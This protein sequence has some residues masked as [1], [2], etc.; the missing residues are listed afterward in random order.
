MKTNASVSLLLGL[1]LLLVACAGQV[2]GDGSG[3][4]A[5]DDASSLLGPSGDDASNDG[6][7]GAGGPGW[8]ASLPPSNL[9]GSADGAQGT[10]ARDG[11]PAGARPDAS[12]TAPLG[13]GTLVID[14]LMVESVAGTG[15]YGEWL[16]VRSTTPCAVSLRGLHG[17]CPVGMKVHTFDVTDDLWVGPLG[18]FVVADSTDP[19][20]NHDVPGLLVGWAGQPGDVLRNKGGTVT[21]T[22]SDVIVDSVTFPALKLV[23]GASV[24]FPSSCPDSRRSDWSSWQTSNASWFPG[25]YG[26]PNAP[27]DDVTCP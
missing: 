20:I 14:E 13:P 5:G 22:V 10:D 17:S 23:V 6:E 4:G 12:C 27:N 25:F 3:S 9:D 18:T 24:A 21:L 15:D 16:E 7:G 8:D 19:A 2:N 11:S 1:L 26:T